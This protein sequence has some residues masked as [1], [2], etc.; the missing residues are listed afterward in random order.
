MKEYQVTVFLPGGGVYFR[1]A[2]A[3]G[4]EQAKGIAK[5]LGGLYGTE[6]IGLIARRL[7]AAGYQIETLKRAEVWTA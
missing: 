5:E 6:A 7:T 4:R 2:W 1:T 3:E